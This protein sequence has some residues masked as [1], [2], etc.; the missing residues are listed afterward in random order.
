MVCP[1]TLKLDG[2]FYRNDVPAIVIPWIPHGNINEYLANHPNADRFRLVSLG[3]YQRSAL[4]H[5]T[6]HLCVVFMCG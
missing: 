6:S 5:L 4:A 2:L 1:Y 3:F